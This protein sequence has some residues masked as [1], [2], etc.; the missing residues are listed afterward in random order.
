MNFEH[1]HNPE[2]AL[3]DAFARAGV[4]SPEEKLIELVGPHWSQHKPDIAATIR[5]FAEELYAR[6]PL[7]AYIG[8]KYRLN[9]AIVHFVQAHHPE[10]RRI[11]RGNAAGKRARAALAK[12][13]GY[14]QHPEAVRRREQRW[15][16]GERTPAADRPENN[17]YFLQTAGQ[18]AVNKRIREGIVR[19]RVDIDPH[20]KT[21]TL[22]SQLPS[23]L[24]SIQINGLPVQDVTKEAALKWCEL[25]GKQTAMVELWC[26]LVADPRKTLGEQ[27]TAEIVAALA[28]REAA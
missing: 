21:V 28:Q 8:Q 16:T 3:A 12:N 20:K 17:T 5:S 22:A 6:E 27:L 4:K 9:H 19:V 15:A 24:R 1:T 11:I 10:I 13:G 23:T 7:L 14:S 25:R 26:S 18:K 2:T